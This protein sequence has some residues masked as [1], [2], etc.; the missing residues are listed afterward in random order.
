MSD[1]EYN[2]ELLNMTFDPAEIDSSNR[3]SNPGVYAVTIISVE[4]K[5]SKSNK[6]TAWIT[7]EAKDGRTH[8]DFFSL[9]KQSWWRLQELANACGIFEAGQWLK[10][11]PESSLTIELIGTQ[12]T[13]SD[14]NPKSGVKIKSMY[15]SDDEIS[16]P[17][18]PSIPGNQREVTDE[19]GDPF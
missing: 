18:A 4:A 9:T 12:F 6:P 11:L 16:E 7:F 2:H 5:M 1:Q 10:Q 17:Q 14:G 3:I 19:I 15:R 13:G 8:L